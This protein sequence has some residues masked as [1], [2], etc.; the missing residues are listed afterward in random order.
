[1]NVTFAFET[2]LAA[3]RNALSTRTAT[4]VLM[5]GALFSFGI[6]TMA[7]NIA[8]AKA[9]HGAAHSAMNGHDDIVAHVEGMLQFVYDEVG[10]TQD[11]KEKLAAISQQAATDLASLNDTSNRTHSQIFGLLTQD[12]IDRTAL[13]S[14]REAHMRVAEQ[15]SR[16]ATQFFADVAETLT[17]AQRKALADHFAQHAG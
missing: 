5:A 4:M 1:M 2:S 6:D 17:P 9:H 10:A 12:K 7:Q 11:Q 13:E 15:A 16:R 8:D 3:I 14:V